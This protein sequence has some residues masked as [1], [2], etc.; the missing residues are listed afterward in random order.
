MRRRDFI[1]RSVGAGASLLVPASLLSC[2][3]E[4]DADA[5]GMDAGRRMDAGPPPIPRGL[6]KGPYVQLL[7]PGRAR[8][9][10][11]TR[12]DVPVPVR[13]TRAGGDDEPTATRSA[14][15]LEYERFVIGRADYLP[16]DPGL[17]VVHEVLLEGLE[18]GER[19]EWTVTPEEG[20]PVSGGFTAPVEPGAPFRVAWL[21]D[22]SFPMAHDTI[23]K[24]GNQMPDLV[25]HGGDI[26]YQ[27]NPFDT[28]NEM[29]SGMATLM[30]RAP[31]HFAVG[32]HE[33]EAQMEVGVQFDRLFGGQGAASGSDRYFAFTY[34]AARVVVIDT[35]SGA[36]ETM[37]TTQ[38]AWLDAELAAASAD[39]DILHIVPMFHRPTYTLSKHAPGDTTVRDLL[40]AMFQTHGVRLVLAGHAHCYERFLV[41]G[42]Q[43][44]VDGGGGALLYDPNEDAEE[45]ERRRPGESMLRQAVSR[46]QGGLS[47]EVDAS[48]AMT[49]SRVEAEDAR[50]SD[51]F[52]V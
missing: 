20:G 9:R 32:N 44:V 12:F 6:S 36:L 1:R 31:V 4:D 35:E 13:L 48:G 18:A 27:A 34:G 28:W 33:F 23:G 17:H 10:F 37:D 41:D 29:M 2:D 47:I 25:L 39:P 21:S 46:S 7:E 49:V 15:E 16:D 3:G 19:V 42:I 22:T 26:T 11:E 45:V 24:L 38:L 50:V 5:G 30:R 8:L 40:H 14:M 52:T 51:Q 43:Y